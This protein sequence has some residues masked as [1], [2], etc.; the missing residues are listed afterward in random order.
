M[1]RKQSKDKKII[2]IFDLDGT[3][4]KQETLPLIANAFNVHDEIN[5]LTHQTVSGN[6]PFVEGFIQRVSILGRFDVNEIRELLSNVELFEG[7]VDF[8]NVHKDQCAI[9]TGNCS[10]WV[11]GIAKR[12]DCECYSSSAVVED[13]KIVK[14]KSILKKEDIVKSYQAR[15][16]QV[17]FIGDGNNDMEAMREADVSIA[18]GLVHYPANSILSIA[19]YCVFEEVT[20]LRLLQQINQPQLGN[21][22]VLSCAG[23]GSRL[24]LAKTKAL[25]EIEG[26]K[27]IHFQLD[28]FR[29]VEDLRVVIGYQAR[30]VIEAVLELRKD[31]L[32]VYNH[33]YFQTKTGT[34]YY[35][36]SRHANEYCV[37]WDGDLVVH[38]DD[39]DKCIDFK[40]EYVGCSDIVSEDAVFIKTDDKG[41]VQSFS[42]ENGDYEWSGPAK[43]KRCNIK[44]LS[45]NVYNQIEGL[46]P[47]PFLKIRAQDV[48]T[49]ADYKNVIQF[50]KS[51]PNEK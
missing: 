4:T 24:G 6:I 5:T 47:L 32:F 8:I 11:D 15:G 45:T 10:E 34:S 49:Y 12:L 1:M 44:Y 29:Q 50:I 23:I 35:L 37:A 31:V 42:V 14:L 26:K 33:D 21:S 22:V 27:L 36:G 13:D 7:I 30:S 2:F 39:V 16:H 20:L 18:C 28:V 51:W 43:I 41:R 3:V 17:V 38:P 9:A 19:D 46:L 48:D 25:I 40:G